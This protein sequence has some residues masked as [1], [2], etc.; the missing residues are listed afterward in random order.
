MTSVLILPGIGGSGPEHWQ[1]LWERKHPEYRRVCVPDWDRPDVDEWVAAL[2]AEVTAAA[3]PVVVVAHSLGCLV[4][5]H[6]V[7]RGGRLAGA[8]LVA[9]PDPSG[10]E[11]PPA[12]H[13]FGGFTR[14][15]FGFAS[16]VVASRNDP[17]ASFDFAAGCARAWG[18]ALTDVGHVGH[19]NA[20]SGLGDWPAGQALLADLLA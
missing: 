14:S 2:S 12:A 7:G 8:L 10:P 3:A 6:Y 15:P 9:V 17:Y 5:A 20:A 16:R 1:T 13:S 11:F 19:I 18:S 4:V